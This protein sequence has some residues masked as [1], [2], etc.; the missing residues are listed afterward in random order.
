MRMMP[1]RLTTAFLII[2]ACAATDRSGAKTTS[3]P[4]IAPNDPPSALTP[5]TE[6]APDG[7]VLRV[8][9][10]PGRLVGW[11]GGSQSF[12]GVVARVLAGGRELTATIG[13]DNTFEIAVNV[14]AS[15]EAT[16]RAGDHV[17]RV[18]LE[19]AAKPE[20]TAYLIVDRHAYRPGQKLSFTGFL[21]TPNKKVEARIVSD[22]KSTTA[23]KIE[24]T[25]DA[26]GRI[27]GEYTF[28]VADP[29]DGYTISIPGYRGTARVTLSEFRKSKVKLAVEAGL[30]GRHAELRFRALDF[31]DKPVPGGTVSFNAQLVEESETGA[32]DVAEQFAHGGPGRAL[33]REDELHVAA[34]SQLMGTTSGRRVVSEI[35][36]KLE[37]DAKGSATHRLPVRS[38]MTRGRHRLLVDATIVDANGRE[39][40]TTK[41]LPLGR[42]DVRVELATANELVAA[43]SP[44]D[45]AV[46][47]VDAHGR[48]ITPASASIAAIRIAPPQPTYYGYGGYYGNGLGWQGG[49][50]NGGGWNGGNGLED[51]YVLI[52]PMPQISPNGGY[53]RGRRFRAA[54]PT[55]TETLAATAAVVG[56]RVRIEL[57]DAGAYRLVASARLADGTS[58]WSELGI[59]VR[60]AEAGPPLVIELD[61]DTIREGERITGLVRG[62]Y[63]DTPALVVLRDGRGIRSRHRIMLT[64]GSARIDLPASDLGF[65]AAVEAYVMGKQRAVH[66]AQQLV[67]VE[68][69]SKRL[70]IATTLKG[71]QASGSY[72]PG[73]FVDLEITTGANANLVVSVFDQSLLGVAPDRS[74]DP[75]AFFHADARIH[76]R[77]ALQTLRAEL[78]DRTIGELVDSARDL[79]KLPANPDNPD[80]ERAAE[81]SEAATFAQ[82]FDNEHAMTP[83]AAITLLRQVGI[84]AVFATPYSDISFP[85]PGRIALKTMRVTDYLERIPRL[86]F[87]RVADTLV[88]YDPLQIG[89]ATATTLGLGDFNVS[90]NASYSHSVPVTI[91]LPTPLDVGDGSTDVVRRDFSDSAYWN[92]AVRAD[93]SGKAFVRFKLPDSLTNWQVVVTAVTPDLRAGRHVTKL[94]TVR[95]VMIWPMLPRQFTEGDVV[96]IYGS[97]HN[98]TDTDREVTVTLKAEGVEILSP[99]TVS[100]RVPRSSNVP[101][102]W[103]VRAP[104]SVSEPGMAVLLM[105]V[106]GLGVADASLKRIP[107]VASAATEV[108]TAS[109]FA[110]RPLKVT[111]PDGVDPRHARLELSFAPTLAADMLQTLDYLVDYPYGCAEQTM[112]RFAP[113]IRVAGILDHLGIRDGALVKKLPGVASSGL[114]RLTELQQPDGGWGWHGTSTT[115]EMITPYVVWG[116]LEADKAGHKL[117]DDRVLPRGIERV[118]TLYEHASHAML[119]DRTYL[120]YVYSQRHAV[121]AR[122]WTSIVDSREQLSDYAA[123]LA[124]EMAVARDDKPF[125]A[126]LVAMLRTRAQKDHGGK[127]WQTARFSRWGDDPFETTAAVLKALAK[128]DAN[129]PLIPEVIT[130][131]VATKRGDRWNSTKDTA[132]ILYAITELLGKKGAQSMSSASV[133][134]SIDHAAPVHLGFT[135]GRP[136]TVTVDGSKLATTTTIKFANSTPGMIARAV[137]RYRKTGRSLAPSSHGLDVKREVFLLGAKG[138][139]V[140]EL[141]AGDR[142]PRG[143][144]VESLV[145]VQHHKQQM[146]QFMLVE[147]PKPAGAEAL[148]VDDPRFLR[149]PSGYPYAGGYVLREDRESHMAFHFE[150]A[151][152]TTTVRT[153]LHLELSG[154]IAFPPAQSELMYETQTRGHSGSFA[155]K[156]D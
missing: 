27:A 156:V 47:V 133:D 89:V 25:S 150:Q 44:I 72:G 5:A 86:A 15:T 63:R 106:N 140:K 24:L 103:S 91:A 62:T 142:I 112:S 134:Y 138:L 109:G 6:P 94:R 60:D 31:L 10:E 14:A 141:H 84:S 51:N 23:A 40:R 118:R 2:A 115:H 107:I 125:A 66:S 28:S 69:T 119:S 50:W 71:A 16:V 57:E 18:T 49:G 137:L 77:A 110:D 52:N 35:K 127:H 126:K 45:V 26:Q 122:W 34:W 131:F 36:A 20:P 56:D 82:Q 97:V 155:L 58:V 1:I 114:K 74:V 59:A 67:R 53:R 32:R 130:Y 143:S 100:I 152:P 123:A 83:H 120:A 95:D 65:G 147:D 102:V 121:P 79:V 96:S 139:R 153:V 151:N 111:L 116:L 21:Q 154:D 117:T 46:K 55:T 70:P 135:D 128:Y 99:A 78:G 80:L 90:G 144:Y 22:T 75:H 87:R 105:S 30:V 148:P 33:S 61:R 48:A 98:T 42:S 85:H 13:E 92:S 145:T 19:P 124:L 93:S 108:V 43:G 38:E 37:L 136:R 17:Q 146:M 11:V 7:S 3:S 8:F 113:A 73:D 9:V 29:L 101:I 76:S 81:R 41:T 68:Q 149:N 12:R 54:P 39:Q 88:L 64:D 104:T 132:M 4:P 129:D